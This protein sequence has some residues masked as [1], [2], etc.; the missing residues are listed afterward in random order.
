MSDPFDERYDDVMERLRRYGAAE[1]TCVRGRDGLV[2]AALAWLTC[3]CAVTLV[4]WARSGVRPALWLGLVEKRLALARR[5]RSD[6]GGG[7][8]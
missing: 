3:W 8:S 4:R 2:R 7:R 1:V 5:K 6:R